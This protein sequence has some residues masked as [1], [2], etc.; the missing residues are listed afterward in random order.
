LNRARGAG[1]SLRAA[2]EMFPPDPA[3]LSPGFVAPLE[4]LRLL[5]RIALQRGGS[6][7]LRN[8]GC[9]GVASPRGTGALWAKD[10][11]AEQF[12]GYFF[13]TGQHRFSGCWSS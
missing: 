11:R 5:W 12:K 6:K 2:S 1:P 13:D 9:G 4:A 8:R 7:N 3:P 10:H